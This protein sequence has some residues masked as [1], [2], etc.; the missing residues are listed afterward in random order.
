MDEKVVKNYAASKKSFVHLV[1]SFLLIFQAGCS[2]SR[3]FHPQATATTTVTS[4]PTSTET[5]TP[6]PSET[7]TKVPPPVS[8]AGCL[9]QEDCPSARPVSKF[10]KG[11][12]SFSYNV[13]YP[14]TIY[15]GMQVW[16]TYQWCA[17]DDSILQANMEDIEF[18]FTID[19]VSYIENLE[20]G[21]SS[22]Q[23][24]NDPSVIYPCHSI[25]GVLSKGITGQTYRVTIGVRLPGNTSN[26][27]NTLGAG[28]YLN[29][30]LVTKDSLASPVPI[31]T[32][33]PTRIPPTLAPCDATSVLDIW[34]QSDGTA[35]FY[36]SGPAI[37]SFI[38]DGGERS[39]FN[40]CPGDYNYSS[41]ACEI[42]QHVGTMTIHGGRNWIII[43]C[44]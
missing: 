43:E 16:L 32:R 21:S 40:V 8:I 5:N 22:M 18:V 37:Y 28:D 38:M 20:Q 10:F 33:T 1:L 34:N 27:W 31:P 26:G 7:P 39:L 2:I 4:R 13:E 17:K 12:D 3:P 25:G 23:D 30:F 41:V 11:Q 15:S 14:L 19:G 24:E 42:T 6:L 44:H 36:I 35:I 9:S 29:V